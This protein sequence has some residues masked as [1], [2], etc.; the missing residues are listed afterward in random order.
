MFGITGTGLAAVRNWQNEGK[1]P[2]YNLDKWA[3][4]SLLCIYWRLGM[5]THITA[6]YVDTYN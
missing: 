2:R 4:V 1:N 6:K 5:L 3:E